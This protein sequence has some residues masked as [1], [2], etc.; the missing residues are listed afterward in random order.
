MCSKLLSFLVSVLLCRNVL[1]CFWASALVCLVCSSTVVRNYDV[2]DD[3]DDSFIYLFQTTELYGCVLKYTYRPTS[4]GVCTG[5][6]SYGPSF[7]DKGVI[8]NFGPPVN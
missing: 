5:A 6:G 3:D 2:D 1:L 4:R 7:S 8:R